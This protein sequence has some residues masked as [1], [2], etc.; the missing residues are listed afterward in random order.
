LEI[1]DTWKLLEL[2]LKV[3]GLH[4]PVSFG[5]SPTGQDESVKNNTYAIVTELYNFCL[6]PWRIIILINANGTRQT[7]FDSLIKLKNTDA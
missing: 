1:Q 2:K 5:T 6:C 3:R 7:F 4:F